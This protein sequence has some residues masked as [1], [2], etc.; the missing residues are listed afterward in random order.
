MLVAGQDPVPSVSRQQSSSQAQSVEE[1]KHPVSERTQDQL[2]S[3][4]DRKGLVFA[5]SSEEKEPG[6]PMFQS[7]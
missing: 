2:S 4:K 3:E 6:S 7:I 1:I 5:G